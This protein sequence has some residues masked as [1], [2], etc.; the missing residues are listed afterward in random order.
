MRPLIAV[1]AAGSIVVMGILIVAG[2]NLL[3]RQVSVPQPGQPDAITIDPIDPADLPPEVSDVEPEAEKPLPWRPS[4]HKPPAPETQAGFERVEPRD[5][6]SGIGQAQPPQQG[7]PRA[8]PLYRPVAS[9]AGRI[10]AM[11]YTVEIDNIDAVTADETCTTDG[12]QWQCGASA[13]TAF[14][15]FL[16]GRAVTC[17]VPPEPSKQSVISSCHIGRQDIGEWLVANGWARAAE[18]GPYADAGE[19][20]QK[21][22]K[23]V[24]G[25]P[26]AAVRLPSVEAPVVQEPAPETG[27]G[28][29]PPAPTPPIVP[30]AP[31]E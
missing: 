24:F 21:A 15:S 22:G 3:D 23:G 7:E 31:S 10:E 6:L 29:F 8:K 11:G 5:P 2:G 1:S 28:V 19:A 30:T 27:A 26:P 16:R 17:T 20:A 4:R 13:R 14:R 12:T 18:G 9:A 25:R